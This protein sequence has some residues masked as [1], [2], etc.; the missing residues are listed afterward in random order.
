MTHVIASRKPRVENVI[1]EGQESRTPGARHRRCRS[2]RYGRAALACLLTLWAAPALAQAPVEYTLSFP[3]PEHRWMQVRIVFPDLPPEPLDV[4]FPRASPGRYALH[5]FVKNVYDVRFTGASGNRIEALRPDVHAWSVPG[6]EGRVTM[7]Y[8]VYGDQLDGTYLAI[9]VTHAHINMPAALAWAPSLELRPARVTFESPAGRSWEVA[10][11]LMPTRDPLV[12]TAPN[13][14]Y[15]MDSP[16]EFGR[17]TWRTFLAPAASAG[18]GAAPL[19]RIALHH[20]GSDADA[21]EFAGSVRRIVA[22]SRE[23]FGEYPAFENGTYTFLA[24]YLPWAR[25][26]GMEHRNSTVLT[27]PDSIGEARE[28]LLGTVAHEFLHVWNVERVRPRSLEPFDF[29]RANVS[30]DLWLAEGVTSYYDDLLLMRAGLI[31]LDELVADLASAVDTVLT[32]PSHRFRS[33]EDMSRMAPLV[34]AAARVDRT[35][36][37]NT[38]ISYYTFGAALGLG[39]DLAIRERTGN[40]AS[41][42]D[43]MRAM[44][45]THGRPGGARPGY[46]DQPYTSADVIK[47]LAAVTGDREF[48]EGLIRRYVQG[49]EVMDYRRLLAQA[50]L[51][52]RPRFPD[53]ASLGLVSTERADGVKVA[54]PT[55]LGSAAYRAGLDQNDV[56]RAIDGKPVSSIGQL[57]AMMKEHRPG[58]RVTVT[59]LRRGKQVRADVRLDVDPRLELVTLESTGGSLTEAQQRFRKSW[60][61]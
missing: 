38:Y 20:T 58:D 28:R 40:R 31:T 48:A 18:D 29:R 1:A 35:N 55:R 59:F 15:L 33:A 34:D 37:T 3:E 2:A 7:A 25:S 30:P 22:E 54:A 12:F 47:Q 16:A 6:H 9:D 26:D 46:V 57:E 56:L 10:T 36:W 51:I 44:W 5:E 61:E 27:S 43:F 11:Q 53:R 52:L 4:R 39:F 17:V 13:L 24:D 32:S 14:Q 19:V 45:R 42:D 49:R 21:D 50:G 41:L 8:R 60:L 23:L